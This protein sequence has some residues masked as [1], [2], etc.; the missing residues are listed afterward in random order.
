MLGLLGDRGEAFLPAW[1]DIRLPRSNAFMRSSKV[2]PKDKSSCGK[3]PRCRDI[4][5][6]SFWTGGCATCSSFV[7]VRGRATV[8]TVGVGGDDIGCGVV[9]LPLDRSVGCGEGQRPGSED[10]LGATGSRGADL[11]V[12]SRSGSVGFRSSFRDRSMSSDTR[13]FVTGADGGAGADEVALGELLSTVRS[14]FLFLENKPFSPPELFLGCTAFD[15]SFDTSL[16]DSCRVTSS[17][18][19][20][21]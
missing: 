18:R 13:R 21:P 16:L 5:G 12:G 6:G 10:M 9:D 2:E 4:E 11:S 20:A 7:G 14:L 3:S 17:E 19:L 8:S 15:A 1:G